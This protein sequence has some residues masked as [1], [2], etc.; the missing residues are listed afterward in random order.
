M[1]VPT[2]EVQM[3]LTL[4]IMK[5]GQFP[6][7]GITPMTHFDENIET[8]T[9]LFPRYEEYQPKGLLPTCQSKSCDENI[10][11]LNRVVSTPV[12]IPRPTQSHG[13]LFPPQP[14]QP[15]PFIDILKEKITALL[16]LISPEPTTEPTKHLTQ[17]Q[18]KELGE[19]I[20]LLISFKE[21]YDDISHELCTSGSPNKQARGCLL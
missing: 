3:Q 17:D 19:I 10:N 12:T 5:L 21:R 1:P 16:K 8:L 2:N 9:R 4:L 20:N 7:S 13:K 15:K 18:E 6:K 14:V 11:T